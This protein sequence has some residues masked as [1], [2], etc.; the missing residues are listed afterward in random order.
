MKKEMSNGLNLSIQPNEEI[1]FD[2]S[3][4]KIIGQLVDSTSFNGSD[5]KIIYELKSKCDEMIEQEIEKNGGGT[6]VLPDG[7]MM[8]ESTN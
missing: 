5:A 1:R 7:V 8:Q 3:Q 4:L 2:I 6:M